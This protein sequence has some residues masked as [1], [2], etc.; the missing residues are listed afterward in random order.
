MRNASVNIHT[1]QS[2]GNRNLHHDLSHL[3]FQIELILSQKREQATKCSKKQ[4]TAN[5][6]MPQKPKR[7]TK[8]NKEHFS[9]PFSFI[10]FNSGP[11][12]NG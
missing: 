1:D 10:C 4:R 8:G 7:A 5:G 11:M 9:F 6:N 12:E 2:V 3:H